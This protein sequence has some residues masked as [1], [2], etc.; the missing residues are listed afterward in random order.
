M[1]LMVL[2]R[3]NLNRKELNNFEVLINIYQN[4]TMS[5]PNNSEVPNIPR[6]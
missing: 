5:A 4:S 6:Y 3:M 1:I 2:W